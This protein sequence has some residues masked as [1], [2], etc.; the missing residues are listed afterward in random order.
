[1]PD[2]TMEMM[3]RLLKLRVVLS[4]AG[5][6]RARRMPGSGSYEVTC[7]LPGSGEFL[8]LEDDGAGN[9][10]G[11]LFYANGRPM[12]VHARLDPRFMCEGL[13]HNS[14]CGIWQSDCDGNR[15]GSKGLSKPSPLPG[16]LRDLIDLAVAGDDEAVTEQVEILYAQ[17]RTAEFPDLRREWTLPED[18]RAL[19][20]AAGASSNP[21]LSAAAG[22]VLAADAGAAPDNPVTDEQGNEWSHRSLQRWR[23]LAEDWTQPR[24]APGPGMR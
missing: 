4:G 12:S 9:E 7:V 2:L 1:M 3:A 5:A 15:I 21:R 17:G 11:Q 8:K 16:A 18:A 23:A 24:P 13:M 22:E 10:R 19:V 20:E 14:D 6:F